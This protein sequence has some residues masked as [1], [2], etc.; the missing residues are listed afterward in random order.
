MD[1]KTAKAIPIDEFLLK[2]GIRPSKQQGGRQWYCS[3]FRHENTPSFVLSKDGLAFF[4]HGEGWGGNIIDLAM[5]L[6]QCQ[7]VSTALTYL[8]DLLGQKSSTRPHYPSPLVATNEPPAY[9]LLAIRPFAVY[10]PAGEYTQEA[11]YLRSRSIDP[12]R[13]APF[14]H[15]I[16]FARQNQPTQKLQGFGLRN[17]AGGYE[18]RARWQQQYIKT[19]VGPKA[20]S[21]FSATLFEHVPIHIEVFEGAPDFYTFLTTHPQLEPT[22]SNFLILNG[23][24]QVNKALQFLGQHPVELVRLWAHN[25]EAGRQTG[26]AFLA[27]PRRVELMNSLY[28]GFKDYNEWHMAQLPLTPGTAATRSLSPPVTKLKPTPKIG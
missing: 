11:V 22:Q 7:S 6:G 17:Q 14:V 8:E 16:D 13:V 12:Q 1:I 25:D 26:E 20:F 18:V 19:C 3:P 15:Q 4:D 9:Q 10:T 24:G 27:L 28:E 23:T 2:L 21:H 5:R